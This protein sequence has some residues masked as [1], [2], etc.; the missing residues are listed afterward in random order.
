M[1]ICTHDF[2]DKPKNNGEKIETDIEVINI[3]HA[4]LN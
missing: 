2:L 1:P 3:S 4:Q